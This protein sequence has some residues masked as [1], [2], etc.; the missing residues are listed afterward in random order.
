MNKI[1]T[2]ITIAA[3]L[4]AGACTKTVVEFDSSPVTLDYSVNL[5][6]AVTKSLGDGSTVDMLAY[7]IYEE[8]S[9]VAYAKGTIDKTDG[10]FTFKPSLYI[11]KEYDII[12]F[13]YKDDSDDSYDIDNLQAV[14]R[15]EGLIG[16]NADAF[17]LKETVKIDKDE[18]LYVNGENKGSF[19]N[20][21]TVSL[22]RPFAQL[23]IGT[24]SLDDLDAVRAAKVKVTLCDYKTSYNVRTSSMNGETT[25]E[26]TT[27]I[28]YDKEDVK[29]ET[30]DIEGNTYSYVSLNYLFPVGTVNA[31]VTVLTA[32]DEPI[33]TILFNNLPLNANCKTNIYGNLVKGELTFNVSVVTGFTPEDE[34][35]VVPDNN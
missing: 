23:N 19:R 16:E 27:S 34:D 29:E 5:D 10:K 3:V 18:N 9:D 32:E 22:T 12:L 13:A 17:S 11:G 8:Q 15:S 21:R 33:R 25:Y 28:E 31:T 35:K 30:F 6:N 7:A 26:Y 20:P 1:T 2:I 24:S 14:T 4:L